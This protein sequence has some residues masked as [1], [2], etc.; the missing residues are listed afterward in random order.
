VLVSTVEAD[1][2]STGRTTRGLVVVAIVSF[3]GLW[4]YVLYLAVF[5]GRQPPADRLEDPTFALSAED[6]CADAL[7]LVDELP[8]ATEATTPQ[9]RAMVLDQANDIFGSMLAEL[10]GMTTLVT[11]EDELGRLDAWLADWETF[12][13]DREAHAGRL[14]DGEDSRLIV[15]EKPGEG[16]HIT[17]WIDEFA[18]A[19][20]M[21]SCVSP[22]DA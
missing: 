7:D 20:K 8:L 2:P 15:S 3:V 6:V 1:Q 9:E 17:G 22:A 14:S 10:D 19:N 12:L 16:R 4:G 13:G 5:E 11:D 21:D 18:L